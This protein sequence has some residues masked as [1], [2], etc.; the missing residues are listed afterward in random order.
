M[1]VSC[2]SSNYTPI[3]DRY[4]LTS[5][6]TSEYSADNVTVTVEWTQQV[7]TTYDVT[8]VPPVPI[9]FTESTSCQ[10]TISY[11]TEYN[12]TVEA[13]APCRPNTTALLRLNYGEA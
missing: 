2:Y 12:L 8:V 3:I 13:A 1:L 6:N 10:L 4:P 5:R 9:V 7:Y 11:N